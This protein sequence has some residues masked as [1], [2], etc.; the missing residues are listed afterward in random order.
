MKAKTRVWLFSLIAIS[1]ICSSA[2]VSKLQ[3]QNRKAIEHFDM[4]SLRRTACYGPC[5]IYEVTIY[6][7]GRVEFQGEKFVKTLEKENSTLTP[8]QIKVL[9]EAFNEA[10]F[11]SLK[12]RYKGSDDECPTI[13]TD[14]PSAYITFEAGG[15]RKSIVHYY[16]CQEATGTTEWKVYPQALYVLGKRIDEIVGTERWIGTDKE[17][18]KN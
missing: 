8:E 9:I 5:P 11:F 14:N 15:R 17:R 16:G 2:R 7:D 12:D 18:I 6:G 10:D 1:S 4:I 13:W 3:S